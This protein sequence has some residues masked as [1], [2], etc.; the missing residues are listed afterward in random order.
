MKR[1]MGLDLG[2]RTIGVAVSDPLMIMAQ[3][4]TTIRREENELERDFTE[5]DKIIKEYNVAKIVIGLPKNMNGSIGFQGEKTLDFGKKLKEHFDM[6]II[7]EDER[8]TTM[9]AE[10]LLIS[11]DVRRENRKKVI[12]KVAATYI[13]Q[14]YIDRTGGK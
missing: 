3:G 14:T 4:L 12:D 11:G 7:Y 2:D 13:L 5:L 9:A 10:K 1:V 6:E 8:L